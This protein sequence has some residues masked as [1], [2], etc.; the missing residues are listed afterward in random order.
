MQQYNKTIQKWL[1]LMML[2]HGSEYLEVISWVQ[3]KTYNYLK[4]NRDEDK[5]AKRYK[6]CKCNNIIKQY[7]TV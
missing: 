2:W 7:E 1:T 4:D 3:A 5:M 6:K